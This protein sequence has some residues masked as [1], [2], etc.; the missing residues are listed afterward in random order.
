MLLLLLRLRMNDG[1]VNI[2]KEARAG[3]RHAGRQQEGR[4]RVGRQARPQSPIAK[5]PTL[6]NDKAPEGKRN[7]RRERSNDSNSLAAP[8]AA[9]QRE[10][11]LFSPMAGKEAIL[12]VR[13]LVSLHRTA[14]AMLINRDEGLPATTA[15]LTARRTC[16]HQHA[17][18]PAPINPS[19]IRPECATAT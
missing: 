3:A 19:T 10:R 18:L 11:D 6:T 14:Q 2:R 5:S 9:I 16:Q 17:S 15:V 1:G 12:T 4:E 8:G 13:P 7:T